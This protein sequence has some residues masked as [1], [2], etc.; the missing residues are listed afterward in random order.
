AL[1]NILFWAAS[2][3]HPARSPLTRPAT[4]RFKVRTGHER[5]PCLN[6]GARLSAEKLNSPGGNHCPFIRLG[7]DTY[8]GA[9]QEEKRELQVQGCTFSAVPIRRDP[10]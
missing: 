7:R 3:G 5:L 6:Q 1:Q 10:G 8:R 2:I 9:F 4:R